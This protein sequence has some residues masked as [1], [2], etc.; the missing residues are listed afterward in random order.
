MKK[1]FTFKQWK[2]AVQKLYYMDGNPALKLLEAGASIGGAPIA[3]ATTNLP[4]LQQD[5]VALGR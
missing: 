1:V 3:V 2:V 5:E 4:G